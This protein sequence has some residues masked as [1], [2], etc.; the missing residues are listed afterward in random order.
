M[1][2]VLKDDLLSFSITVCSI[3]LDELSIQRLIHIDNYELQEEFTDSNCFLMQDLFINANKKY[4]NAVL[5]NL[6]KAIQTNCGNNLDL[7]SVD[8]PKDFG[9]SFTHINNEKE[10]RISKIYENYRIRPPQQ[11][12][13][14][15]IWLKTFVQDLKK[16]DFTI[17]K[18][19]QL[20]QKDYSVLKPVNIFDLIEEYESF[21]NKFQQKIEKEFQKPIPKSEKLNFYFNEMLPDYIE[22]IDDYFLQ[23]EEMRTSF[24]NQF[25]YLDSQY[26]SL[27]AIISKAQINEISN[28][29]SF[30]NKVDYN[31][32]QDL[33]NRFQSIVSRIRSNK[34]LQE[35]G[36]S[37][38]LNEL[39]NR[40]ENILRDEP[41]P[42]QETPPKNESDAEH[43]EA[44][45]K[46]FNFFTKDCPRKGK[47]ILNDDDF[48]KLINWTIYYYE[49]DFKIPEIKEPIKVVNTNMTYVI[50][51]FR[52]LFK[53]L[54]PLNSYPESLFIFFTKA[55]KPYSGYKKTNFDK[56]KNNKFVKELMNIN[57]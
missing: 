15:I 55:F 1:T 27:N 17:R 28:I 45:K 41:Q 4:T 34:N 53:E 3:P 49:N 48:D 16:I 33:K 21:T 18:I 23:F 12:Q 35:K 6:S 47:Q 2:N 19:L 43:T 52:Y 54:Y 13:F 25:G 38:F 20:P 31:D 29:E 14:K 40:V 32:F 42:T 7:E 5:Q 10:K 39:T 11:D 8:I 37:I 24:K 50:L 36:T 9:Y 51:A 57:K 22:K 46:Q 26:N 56:V 44:I 30:F